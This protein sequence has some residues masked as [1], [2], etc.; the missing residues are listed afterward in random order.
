MAPSSPTLELANASAAQISGFIK[1]MGESYG[2]SSLR[3]RYVGKVDAN[4]QRSRVLVL[5]VR[6]GRENI[7]DQLIN[8]FDKANQ[9]ARAVM[10]IGQR[11]PGLFQPQ[12]TKKGM[13]LL[14]GAITVNEAAKQIGE[15]ERRHAKALSDMASTA[16]AAFKLVED[17]KE[18]CVR[19]T[20]LNRGCAGMAFLAGQ[21]RFEH[22][23]RL[24]REHLQVGTRIGEKEFSELFL[25]FACFA[26]KLQHLSSLPL[27]QWQREDRASLE[28][29][30]AFCRMWIA[31]TKRLEDNTLKHP[32]GFQSLQGWAIGEIVKIAAPLLGA[33][34][35]DS[36]PLPDSLYGLDNLQPPASRRAKERLDAYMNMPTVFNVLDLA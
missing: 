30:L 17:S 4:G 9:N 35:F 22:D 5:Y 27:K 11:F 26:S 25:R 31:A 16:A 2:A 36:P 29:G 13:A 14:P 34:N 8:F 32:S 33:D 15:Q 6:T 21:E 1:E 3:A 24:I 20:I 7:V 23:M 10:E 18:A 12:D 19:S 28:Y